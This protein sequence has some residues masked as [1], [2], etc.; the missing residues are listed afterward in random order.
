MPFGFQ[1]SFSVLMR[2]INATM[3]RGL[4]GPASDPSP[5]PSGRL[6][7]SVV[8]YIDGLYATVLRWRNI[9]ATS[10]GS[11]PSCGRRS[12]L[13]RPPSAP[14][15]A[16]SWASLAIGSRQR[17][18]QRTRA[19]SRAYGIRPIPLSKVVLRRFVG[20]CNYYR[21]FVTGY[22]DSAAPFTRLCGPQAPW[23]RGPA[24]QESLDT[25]KQCLT[26]AP[27]L[28]TLDSGRSSVVTTDA[29]EVPISVLRGP[30]RTSRSGPTTRW[31]RG[32]AR[33]GASKAS[34]RA[35]L[36]RSRSSAST[37]STSQAGSTRQIP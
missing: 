4:H 30:F 24:E 9:S 36:T 21:R 3:T 2:V 14:S 6:H 33:S 18:W 29:G 13:S 10:E 11:S 32:C 7:L 35:G 34:S 20:L 15:A 27:V 23:H 8:L 26:T 1:G 37:W 31:S 12:S 17:E 19:R 16:R 5:T 25:L 22:T 28:H